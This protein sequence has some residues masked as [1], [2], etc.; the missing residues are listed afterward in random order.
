MLNINIDGKD[1]SYSAE[2]FWIV[3]V[4]KGPKGGYQSRYRADT[5]HR[6]MW[7]YSGINIGNGY[8]KRLSLITGGKKVTVAR[9]AS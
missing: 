2:D 5:P 3:E 7:Y 8:K 1:W 4:G 6:G 9:S